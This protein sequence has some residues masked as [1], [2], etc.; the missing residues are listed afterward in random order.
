[1]T[2]SLFNSGG[3][4]NIRRTG[5][6]E[7]SLSI[8]LPKDSDGRVARECPADAC[9]PGYFK[10]MTGTGLTDQDQAF[11]P[12]CR[13]GA[14]PSDFATKSQIKYAQ[15]IALR[16]AHKGMDNMIKNAF[17]LG[18]AGKKTYG[19][20]L[21]SLE[22]SYKPGTLPHVRPPFEEGLRRDLICPHCTL[23]HSVFGLAVWCHDCGRDIFMTHVQ[24]EFAV[25]R[26]ILG[27]VDRRA[28]ELGLRVATKDIEN[29]LED[30]VSIFEAV[31]RFLCMRKLREKGLPQT[32]IDTL[33]QKTIRNAFQ[34]I[35]RSQDV[36]RDHLGL[37]LFEGIEADRIQHLTAIF[38]KRHPITHNLGIVDRKY[39]EKIQSGERE[40][41]D[42]RVTVPEIEAAMATSFDVLSQFHNRLF[43]DPSIASQEGD[44]IPE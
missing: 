8:S 32:E 31:L 24:A 40:G 35:P 16:E 21:V 42:V 3:P 13:Q 17:G 29:C 37:E 38:E 4:Y 33:F 34:S 1:M 5:S 18:S 43:P 25:L 12:Y 9:S 27:D 39:L 2:H 11:C 15:D 44:T 14:K 6:D 26:K 41:R 20:G 30:A 7:Y 22:V 28:K 23:D 19:G 36:I 10:V